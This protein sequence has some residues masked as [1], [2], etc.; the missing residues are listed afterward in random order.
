MIRKKELPRVL[1]RHCDDMEHIVIYQNGILLSDEYEGFPNLS[2]KEILEC[3][4]KYGII[5]LEQEE[6]EG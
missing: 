4:A 1:Y 2:G 6:I 5:E 3:F